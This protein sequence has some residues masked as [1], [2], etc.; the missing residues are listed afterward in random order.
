MT[1]YG[2]PVFHRKYSTECF[3]QLW[4]FCLTCLVLKKPCIL[5]S[6]LPTKAINVWTFK[7]CWEA[8]GSISKELENVLRSK[9]FLMLF[10]FGNFCRAKICDFSFFEKLTLGLERPHCGELISML[11]DRA[12]GIGGQWLEHLQ[13]SVQ[14]VLS[15][16]FGEGAHHCEMDR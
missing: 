2:G 8:L 4:A 10:S 16:V 14:S 9:H 13:F 12:V 7:K 5:I 15:N 3:I 6:A 1:L 11:R